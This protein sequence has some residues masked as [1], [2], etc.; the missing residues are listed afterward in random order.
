MR[1]IFTILFV[2]STLFLFS[3]NQ[4]NIWYF[5]DHAGLDFNS[6]APVV[7]TNSN[8]EQTDCSASIAD[9]NGRLLFYSDGRTI[10]NKQNN[11][12]S[13]GTGLLGSFTGGTT[14]LIVPYPQKNYLY[15]ILTVDCFAG[16][17]GLRYSLVDMRLDN[18][19]GAV[20]IKNKLL[21]SPS[22][23]K[24]AATVNAQNNGYWIVTHPY[25][26]G[27]FFC[28]KIDINGLDTVPV[29]KAIGQIHTGGYDGTYNACGQM[30]ISPDNTKLALAVYDMAVIEFFE[31]NNQT[32]DISNPITINNFDN[33][34]GI[35]FSPDSKK[36]YASKWQGS[37]I[38]Q[39]NLTNYDYSSIS[40]SACM[41][42][43]ATVNGSQYQ[44]AYMQLAP[45]RKIY[46]AKYSS[47]FL[48]V[49]NNPDNQGS[50]CNLVDN[51]FNLRPGHS[52]AGLPNFAQP[53]FLTIIP[54]HHIYIDTSIC[55]GDAI[56]IAGHLI[57]QAGSYLDTVRITGIA[58]SI[59]HTTVRTIHAPHIN[60]GSDTT[61][62]YGQSL[63]LT[64]NM[65]G[66]TYI[67]Q[68]GSTQSSYLAEEPG[69][70]YVRICNRCGCNDD[71][72][73]INMKNCFCN[74]FIA[75]AFT[76]NA[77]S[78][79][80]SFYPKFSDENFVSDYSFMIFNRWGFPVFY[81]DNIQQG[82]DGKYKGADCPQGVYFFILNY[83]C[84]NS[85]SK[86]LS[87]SV[88]LLR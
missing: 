41:V 57:N 82:W 19:N 4:N 47:E 68:D 86:T 48:G 79:N 81:S 36:I 39:F 23:E 67:W 45:D 73:R 10:W 52:L 11:I 84:H 49:I 13:N 40:A 38:W 44:A 71:S 9:T 78:F 60:L 77:D 17:N 15:Y 61:V 25:N 58:D 55:E 80:D 24:I 85:E 69:L 50:L 1:I 70:Y 62:C 76:P 72:I 46:I 74:G 7:L 12:M 87:G 26:S 27:Q 35:E 8:I 33:A 64:T 53:N 22:S 5:G 32:G 29:K 51:G 3:Q 21:F 42:G 88:T 14:V 28:Y 43:N 66:V 20:T 18:G 30:K 34:W 54:V 31:F 37:D 65:Q 59:F 16:Y 2:C 6:G 56:F 75:N 83:K 63:I